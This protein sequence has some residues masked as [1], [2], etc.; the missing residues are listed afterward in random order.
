M[1]EGICRRAEIESERHL[2]NVQDYGNCGAAGAPSVL[3][4]RWDTLAEG[5]ELALVVVGSGLTWG[6]VL[7]QIGAA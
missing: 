7:L 4:E 2:Y 1:L 3:S 5:D 6:G